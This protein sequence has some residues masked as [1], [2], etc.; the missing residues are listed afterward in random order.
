MVGCDTQLT[1]FPES[2]NLGEVFFVK[3]EAVHLCHSLS[4][5]FGFCN[6]LL[7]SDSNFLSTFFTSS[8]GDKLSGL[9]PLS[10]N[11][12]LTLSLLV[13]MFT[14]D[15]LLRL[16]LPDFCIEDGDFSGEI[17]GFQ[18]NGRCKISQSSVFRHV[19]LVRHL[20]GGVAE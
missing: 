1:Q 8:S 9:M 5:D 3:S 4:K 2:G 16:H 12:F 18:N 19:P 10:I 14:R 7:A 6:S 11:V 15:F 17:F 20:L 13:T